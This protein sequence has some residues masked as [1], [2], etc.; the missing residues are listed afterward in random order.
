MT[1]TLKFLCNLARLQSNLR[2]LLT[3]LL[4]LLLLA[5]TAYGQIS[6]DDPNSPSRFRAV[7]FPYQAI[8]S[9]H[10]AP[11]YSGPDEVHYATD[12]L[13]SGEV[14]VVY[15][16]DPN[17]W[18]AIQPPA[19][20]FSLLPEAAVEELEDGVG[21][22]VQDQVQA[23]VGTR[24]GSVDK[25]L[26]Q[27]KLRT[28]EEVEIIGEASWPSPDGHS[29]VWYQI[30]PPAGEF[31]WVRMADLKIPSAASRSLPDDRNIVVDQK[32]ARN[33]FTE[34]DIDDDY[35]QKA[36]SFGD[37]I[38]RPKTKTKEKSNARDPS[39]FVYRSELNGSSRKKDRYAA[40]RPPKLKDAAVPTRD[41]TVIDFHFR[42]IGKTA[43]SKSVDPSDAAGGSPALKHAESN[44]DRL[45][46]EQNK[47]AQ[48]TFQSPLP[49]LA[50][51][52][53]WKAAANSLKSGVQSVGDRFSN[54]ARQLNSPDS[55]LTRTPASSGSSLKDTST[56]ATPWQTSSSRN[57][58]LSN[59]VSLD[60][61]WEREN[62]LHNNQRTDADY[63]MGADTIVVGS[64]MF[65]KLSPQLSQLE[66]ALTNEMLKRPNEWQ[67]SDLE[68]TV[69]RIYAQTNNP[70]ERLQA[71]RILDKVKNCKKVRSGY[72][73]S[74]QSTGETFGTSLSPSLRRGRSTPVGVGGLAAAR[75]RLSRFGQQGG[76]VGSSTFGSSSRISAGIQGP[77]GTGVDTTVEAGTLYDAHGWLTELVS[78]DRNNRPVYVLVNDEGKITHH[79]APSPGLNLNRYLKS[80]VGVNGRQGYNNVLKLSHVTVDAVSE[81]IRR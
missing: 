24:L 57:A 12:E 11:V 69:E 51:P 16:H 54:S 50:A 30:S 43:R 25:P 9:A 74:F 52:R 70:V 17:G 6:R 5:P 27:V 45:N 72:A 75:D 3:P 29:T 62:D 41:E 77:V 65:S 14:V 60:L 21:V 80:K 19:G 18:C 79:I 55:L 67:L 2:R 73:K 44:I 53:Q 33:A 31:R 71:Q 64:A 20:S 49:E 7:D 63:D 35:V 36:A 68:L 58:E 39:G 59:D 40:P 26:W 22:L 32:K 1:Y 8:V 42:P 4:V 23:W 13:S 48:A 81:L 46:R 10:N 34:V 38:P 37:Q 76:T 66:I 56:P 78:E 61:Q 15:R 47:V 28:D